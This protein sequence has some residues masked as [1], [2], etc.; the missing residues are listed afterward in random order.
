ML[1]QLFDIV[2][3]TTLPPRYTRQKREQDIEMIFIVY[4]KSIEINLRDVIDEKEYKRLQALD[5]V[6]LFKQTV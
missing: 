5:H 4:L 2:V 3:L 6:L 1:Q